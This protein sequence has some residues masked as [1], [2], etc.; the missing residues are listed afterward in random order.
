MNH[1][2]DNHRLLVWYSLKYPENFPFPSSYHQNALLEHLLDNH[3]CL[4]PF[5]LIKTYKMDINITNNNFLFHWK[6][7]RKHTNNLRMAILKKRRTTRRSRQDI[8]LHEGTRVQTKTTKQAH[9]KPPVS[10]HVY[11][12]EAPLNK[13]LLA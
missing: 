4:F 13:K 1:A 7:K 8:V 3:L 9:E 10:W 12:L 11:T 6:A 2:E 5:L